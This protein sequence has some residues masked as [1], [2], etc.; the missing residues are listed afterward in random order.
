MQ[1]PTDAGESNDY[2]LLH[3][4]NEGQRT[5]GLSSISSATTAGPGGAESGSMDVHQCTQ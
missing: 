3:L 5:A 2:S 4:L 1:T